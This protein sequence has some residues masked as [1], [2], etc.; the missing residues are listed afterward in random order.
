MLRPKVLPLPFFAICLLALTGSLSAQFNEDF[1]Q[2]LE[3]FGK[4]YDRPE[5]SGLQSAKNSSSPISINSVTSRA[6]TKTVTPSTT[7][8]R[9]FAAFG[10]AFPELSH[11][12]GNSR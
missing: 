3:N 10:W 2:N 6:R 11:P 1:C 7:T 4:F 12:I 9:S 5:S 8:S